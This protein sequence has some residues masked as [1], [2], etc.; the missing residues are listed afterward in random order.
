MRIDSETGPASLAD[1][2]RLTGVNKK[3]KISLDTAQSGSQFV[4][5]AHLPALRARFHDP[6]LES[7]LWELGGVLLEIRCSF[8]APSL[9]CAAPCHQD[10]YQGRELATEGK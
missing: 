6:H 10:Q 2:L 9:T 8:P 5:P 3:S 1:P 4:L 7:D